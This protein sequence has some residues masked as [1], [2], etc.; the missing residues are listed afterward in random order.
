MAQAPTKQSTASKLIQILLP[1]KK[2]SPAGTAV[3][4][5]YQANN[6]DAVLSAP[7]YRNHT[8]DIF[9]ERTAN[10]ARDLMKSL[11]KYDSDV[12]AT[13][14]AFL[15]I[16]DTDLR[17]YVYDAEGNI[18]REGM[19]QLDLLVTALFT[20]YD[21]STGFAFAKSLREVAEDLRYMLMLRG[22]IAVELIFDKYLV[23]K[24]LRN[25]DLVTVQWKETQ[26]GLYK[27]SQ[28]VQGNNDGI[29][30]DIANFFVKYYRQNPTEIYTESMFVSS[31]N[32]IASR[33]QVINDLYRIMQKTGY[34]RLEAKVMEEILRKNAPANVVQDEAVMGVWLNQRMQEIA[35]SL[36]DMRPDSAFVHMDSVEVKILNE[37][38]PGKSFDVTSIIEVLNSQ[39]QA[40]LKTMATIIG[41][42]KAGTNTASVE[43]RVFSKSA[44]SLNGPVADI[45][46]DILTFAM[47]MQGYPGFV[48]CEYA[49]VELRPELELEPQRTMLQ[50]RLQ[51][52]LSLGLITDDEYH[53]QMY[54][55]LRPDSAPELSGTGFQTESKAGVDASSISPNSDPLGRSITPKNTKS[56]KSNTVKKVT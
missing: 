26:P 22:G 23:A 7:T 35:N 30:L 51:T 48:W 38:G 45:L 3:T 36:T 6:K 37:G 50:A 46:S 28:I 27:P 53:I 25:V 39:N 11:A 41:R 56:A 31:I 15:T 18:D 21:Y 32:T 9:T 20:R 40:A 5:T 16:A 49:K 2:T 52:D 47:R 55:R 29:S 4:G 19:K 14:H 33:Q 43:A 12:S 13:I 10:D 54:N 1:K 34:P 42:G 17:Y 44:D 8:T 24:E